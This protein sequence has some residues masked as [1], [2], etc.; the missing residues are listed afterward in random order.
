MTEQP[1]TSPLAE[2]LVAVGAQPTTVDANELLRQMAA[3]Q[4]R[5]KAMEAD[6][7]IP[8]DPIEAG[9][10][11]LLAHVQA[12]ANANPSFDFSSVLKSLEGEVTKDG[13]DLIRLR[14]EEHTSELQSPDHLVCRL[15]LEKKNNT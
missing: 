8:S 15:L 6:R 13:A 12:H 7:G 11:N 1:V 10:V 14:S 2:E 5:I 4:D 9:K 3:L